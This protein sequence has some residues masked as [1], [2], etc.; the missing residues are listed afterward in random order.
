[1]PVLF[2]QLAIGYASRRRGVSQRDNITAKAFTN[3]QIN[4]SCPTVDHE[5]I[6]MRLYDLSD[7]LSTQD[8]I[9]LCPPLAVMELPDTLY[10]AAP[11]QQVEDTEWT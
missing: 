1:M 9:H 10:R 6:K 11:S 3:H 2:D 4:K 5:K 7:E 8:E